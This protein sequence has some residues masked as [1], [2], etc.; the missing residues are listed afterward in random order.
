MGGIEFLSDANVTGE[1]Y[2][3]WGGVTRP[4]SRQMRGTPPQ[5]VQNSPVTLASLGNSIPPTGGTEFPST[6]MILNLTLRRSGLDRRNLVHHLILHCLS[7]RIVQAFSQLLGHCMT[8]VW[9]PAWFLVA[10]LWTPFGPSLKN[11]AGLLMSGSW[12]QTCWQSP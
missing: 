4:T 2:T 1:F 8:W 10:S 12:C 6:M 9:A 7:V 3:P 5:G 11:A